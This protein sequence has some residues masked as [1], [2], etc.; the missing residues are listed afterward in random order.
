MFQC[1]PSTIISLVY[2]AYIAQWW[3]HIHQKN[4]K[5][6]MAYSGMLRHVALERSNILEE[7]STS[8]IR[9]TRIGE[10]GTL[11]VTSL[12]SVCIEKICGYQQNHIKLTYGSHHTNKQWK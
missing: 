9:V 1:G 10:L 5:W 4:E 11:A 8:I 12:F 2:L 3:M 6:R 7:L